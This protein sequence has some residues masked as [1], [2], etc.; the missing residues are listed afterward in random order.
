MCLIHSA[1]KRQR[2]GISAL[3]PFL[4]PSSTNLLCHLLIL[5]LLCI[6]FLIQLYVFITILSIFLDWSSSFCCW[7]TACNSSPPLSLSTNLLFNLFN[8]VYSLAA[9]VFFFFFYYVEFLLGIRHSASLLGI[10]N[11][12]CSF[13]K[14]I[15]VEALRIKKKKNNCNAKKSVMI[16]GVNISSWNG[17]RRLRSDGWR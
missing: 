7:N 17:R 15:K 4:P 2:S 5:L 10:T 6:H 11:V 3:L 16:E 9:W 12:A 1:A 14:G 8:S 13:L